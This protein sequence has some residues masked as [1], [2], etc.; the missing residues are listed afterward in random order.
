[1]LVA[2]VADGS[3]LTG[4]YFVGCDHIPAAGEPL[5]RPLP[6]LPVLLQTDKQLKNIC[7]KEEAVLD[8]PMRL[9][10]TEFQERIW[11]EIALIPYG[12]NG[13]L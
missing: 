11:R 7:G 10:G 13:Y 3:R 1:M 12:R 2:D 9:A 8:R 4:V 6:Q 5:E